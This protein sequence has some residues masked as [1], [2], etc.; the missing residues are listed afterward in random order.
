M[1]RPRVQRTQPLQGRVGTGHTLVYGVVLLSQAVGLP[2]R[3]AQLDPRQLLG[4]IH[5]LVSPA[6]IAT[7]KVSPPRQA[8]GV[9][10]IRRDL[11]D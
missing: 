1:I 7:R 10:V 8:I 6:T 11:R 2:L 3:L 4:V 9:N 5:E